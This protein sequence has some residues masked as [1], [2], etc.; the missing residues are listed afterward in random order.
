M[1][2]Y[3]P[4]KQGIGVRFPSCAFMVQYTVYEEPYDLEGDDPAETTIEADHFTFDEVSEYETFAKFRDEDGR[5]VE[6]I[7]AG[8]IRRISME[9]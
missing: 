5:I 6:A 2:R 7:N 8:R 1:V 3:L 9:R 4:S